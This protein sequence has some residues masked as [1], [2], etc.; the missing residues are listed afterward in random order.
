MRRSGAPMAGLVRASPTAAGMAEASTGT[1]SDPTGCPGGSPELLAASRRISG[2][3]RPAV[4]RQG[5]PLGQRHHHVLALRVVLERVHAEVLAVAG[6]L[7]PAVGH[8][9][10]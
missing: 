4:G 9:G 8:L 3:D 5:H 2:E 1:A 10:G 7:E 6:L